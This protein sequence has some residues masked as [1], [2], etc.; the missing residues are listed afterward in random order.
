MAT[1][2]MWMTFKNVPAV[3]GLALI[4][5]GRASLVMMG[6]RAVVLVLVP[7]RLLKCVQGALVPRMLP[8]AAVMVFMVVLV[9]L[10]FPL[11]HLQSTCSHNRAQAGLDEVTALV[12]MT[13]RQFGDL[14]A[15]QGSCSEPDNE[16]DIFTKAD[17]CDVRKSV[18]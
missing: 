6:R 8:A 11:H 10:V 17:V 3:I 12:L 16:V 13:F 2:A 15:C 14:V 1:V 4:L 5:A 9:V 18:L 7:P